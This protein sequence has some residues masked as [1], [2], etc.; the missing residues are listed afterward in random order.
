MADFEYKSHD[1]EKTIVRISLIIMLL[2]AFIRI[3]WADFLVVRE[4]ILNNST[5]EKTHSSE[6]R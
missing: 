6:Q 3:I 5:T 1:I 2:L 4:T